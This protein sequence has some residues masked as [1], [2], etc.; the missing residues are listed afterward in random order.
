MVYF[1]YKKLFEM[2]PKLLQWLSH[3]ACLLASPL[4]PPLLLLEAFLL[5]VSWRE[6]RKMAQELGALDALAQH[7]E[8][9]QHP[10]QEAHIQL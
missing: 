4:S 9:P 10:H 3:S 8:C 7:S 6:A 2:P 5:K 1:I